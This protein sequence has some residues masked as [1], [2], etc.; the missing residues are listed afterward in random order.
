VSRPDCCPYTQYRC[1]TSE[2]SSAVLGRRAA[3]ATDRRWALSADASIAAGSAGRELVW[4]YGR[5]RGRTRTRTRIPAARRRTPSGQIRTRLGPGVDQNANSV[6]DL[7]SN[8]DAD[9]RTCT[10][11]VE[12][13]EAPGAKWRG[14]VVVV[15]AEGTAVDRL[16]DRIHERPRPR[17]AQLDFLTPSSSCSPWNTA[18]RQSST[19]YDFHQRTLR[20]SSPIQFFQ[21][22]AKE[23]AEKNVSEMNYFVSGGK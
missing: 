11:R 8:P 14:G 17:L 18:R 9:A 12:Q 10:R 19:W 23:V 13:P 21:H 20:L 5:H 2:Y 7:D 3:A 15:V 22:Q 4:L 6:P 1:C 16:V